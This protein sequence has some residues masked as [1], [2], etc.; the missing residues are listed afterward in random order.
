MSQE[1]DLE[2]YRAQ[3]GREIGVSQWVTVDQK[4]IDAFADVTD[5]HQYIHVD[6]ARAAE[7]PFG[8]TI[9]HGLLVLSLLSTMAYDALPVIRGTVMGI[10]Y[11]FDRVRFTAPVPVGSRLR[12]RFVLSEVTSRSPEQVLTRF[13]VS[14]EREGADKPVLAADWLTLTILKSARRA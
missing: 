1:I 13:A 4:R 2:D 7:T 5:D 14:V 10:N 6:P 9:A 12:G 11:G 8:G 3:V